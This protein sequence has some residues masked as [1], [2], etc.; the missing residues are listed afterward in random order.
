LSVKKTKTIKPRKRY[1]AGFYEVFL[2]GFIGLVFLLPTLLGMLLIF[3]I[4]VVKSLPYFLLLL[5]H[6]VVRPA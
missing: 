3:A 5:G 1:E 2:G 4:C 6:H